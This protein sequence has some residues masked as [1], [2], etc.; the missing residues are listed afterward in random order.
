MIV[1]HS[2]S[3]TTPKPAT[4]VLSATAQAVVVQADSPE[5]NIIIV[6]DAIQAIFDKADAEGEYAAKVLPDAVQLTSRDGRTV[7][8]TVKWPD[9]SRWARAA[10]S[11]ITRSS[12]GA[13]EEKGGAA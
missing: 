4:E 11:V 13:S 8:E 3:M 2:N 5:S 10:M 12:L 7:Y 9:A 6:P 1:I